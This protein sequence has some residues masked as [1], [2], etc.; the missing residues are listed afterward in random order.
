MKSSSIKNKL[1]DLAQSRIHPP[2]DGSEL[3]STDLKFDAHVRLD[4]INGKTDIAVDVFDSD[5]S[6]SFTAHVDSQ[7]FP[8]TAEGSEAATELLQSYGFCAEITL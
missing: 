4:V 2:E 5:L 7:R 6:D 1:D 8:D 3:A